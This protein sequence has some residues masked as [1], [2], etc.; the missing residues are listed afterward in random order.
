MV[1][2][3][4]KKLQTKREKKHEEQDRGKFGFDR[5]EC[6]TLHQ[7]LACRTGVIFWCFSGERKQARG[8]RGE[9]VTSKGRHA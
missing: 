5:I 9:R 3:F 6:F 8:E 1:S 7:R 2:C 4:H